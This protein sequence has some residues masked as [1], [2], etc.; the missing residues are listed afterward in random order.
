MTIFRM[1]VAACVALVAGVL[2]ETAKA[3]RQAPQVHETALL[4]PR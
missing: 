4:R 1:I 3:E 2:V